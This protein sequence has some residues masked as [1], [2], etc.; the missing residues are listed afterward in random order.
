MECHRDVGSWFHLFTLQYHLYS[1]DSTLYLRQRFYYLVLQDLRATVC[2]L[3]HQR[4]HLSAMFRNSGPAADSWL[5]AIFPVFFSLIDSNHDGVLT[6][7]DKSPLVDLTVFLN[8]LIMGADPGNDYSISL[9]EFTAF[10]N[11]APFEPNDAYKNA[12]LV[13]FSALDLD[14]DQKLSFLD[15]VPV[16]I[17]G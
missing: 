7:A 9:A 2:H 3:F 10:L 11:V 17:L 6:P 12:L 4:P 14:H 8:V 16:N 5:Q 13:M 15:I 1:N